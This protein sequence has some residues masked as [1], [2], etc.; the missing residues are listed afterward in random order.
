M[1]KI[2]TSVV[3]IAASTLY[4]F[5]RQSVAQ[6]TPATPNLDTGTSA[7]PTPISVTDTT[8]PAD[9]QTAPTAP[10]GNAMMQTMPMHGAMMS[11]YRDGTYD[12]ST[13]DAFYGMVQVR[14]TIS[15]GKITNV[16]F[17]SYP[18]DRATSRYIS[19]QATPILAQEAI[20][21]QSANVDIVSGATQT[22]LAFR[23]S[24][25]DALAKALRS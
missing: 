14:M 16:A 25:G 22:S 1:K 21:I 20:Q 2:I 7:A 5:S 3:L 11:G 18:S 19:S 13:A 10:V 23:T 15:G 8:P 12:G 24:L 9:S 6:T 4:L 17:L